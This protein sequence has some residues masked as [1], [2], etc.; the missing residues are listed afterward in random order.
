[1]HKFQTD[2]NSNE[3][4]CYKEISSWNNTSWTDFVSKIDEI[5]EEIQGVIDE[6]IKGSV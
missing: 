5:S 1:L 4:I 3:W 6:I 2:A